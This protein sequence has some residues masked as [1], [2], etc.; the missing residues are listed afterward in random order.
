[1]KLQVFFPTHHYLQIH[2][3]GGVGKIFKTMLEHLADYIPSPSHKKND[4]PG[5]EAMVVVYNRNNPYSFY[6]VI[7]SNFFE[8]KGSFILI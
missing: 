8:V 3:M 4:T 5:H 7:I 2:E 6:R 1:M